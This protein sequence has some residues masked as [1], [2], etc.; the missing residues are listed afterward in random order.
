MIRLIPEPDLPERR[1]IIVVLDGAGV[2][3]L[4]DAGLYGDE[5][6]NTLGNV[7]KKHGPLDLKNLFSLGL[8]RIMQLPDEKTWLPLQPCYYGKMS[9]KSPGKDTTSGHWEL[10]GLILKEPF[11]VYPDGFPDSVIE[12]FKKKIG[13]NILGN[14][15]ASGTEIINKLGDEHLKT[16]YPIVYTSADSVFQVAAHESVVSPDLLYLWCRK[17]RELLKGEHAV[18]RVIARPFNGESGKYVRTS[19]RHD[20]SLQPPDETLLDLVSKAG[21]P[22]AVIGKVA[23]IFAHRGITYHR[24][25]GDNID[26]AAELHYLLDNI[27]GGLIW[28]TFGDFDTV[29]GHRNDS[30]G[31]ALALE[32]FDYCLAAVL[33]K[34]QKADLL[35]ITADHGCDPTH[36]STDHTREYVPIIAKSTSMS[37]MV[38]L[39][40]RNTYADLAAG[41]AQW[42]GLNMPANGNSFID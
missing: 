3:A 15:A 30:K 6:A 33:K 17:A 36:P 1:V 37:R 22:V 26:I 38:D 20:F 24:P 10:A 23:D 28:A 9:P 31:F 35:F 29:F 21:M 19:G 14:I 27:K 39:G 2:G 34:L 40:I 42:L 16:G 7:F 25:G 32:K 13:R 18:G 8:G 12:A 41:T 11:P 4:P 5:D